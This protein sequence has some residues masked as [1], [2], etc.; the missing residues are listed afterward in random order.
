MATRQVRTRPSA[1]R[2]TVARQSPVSLALARRRGV[3]PAQVIATD[4]VVAYRG[5]EYPLSDIVDIAGYKMQDTRPGKYLHVSDLLSKC[6]R[7]RAIH[8]KY[9]TKP[10]SRRLTVS[11]RLTFAQGDAIHDLLKSIA[12]D[13]DPDEVWGKW[14]CKCGELHHDEPCTYSSI[15]RTETCEYCHTLVDVYHEVSMV[16]EELWIV[17]NPDLILYKA[18]YDAYLISELKSIAPD[19][20]KTLARPKPEHVL[21]VV[22][23]WYLMRKLG[24]R[25]LDRV[26]I[27]YASKGWSFTKPFLEFV[28]DPQHELHRLEPMIEDAIAHRASVEGAELPGRTFCSSASAKDAKSCEVCQICFGG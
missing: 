9:G 7:K 28:I 21:Q 16:D 22:F 12:R 6:I 13:G 4:G 10:K 17:G 20:F 27:F 25:V 15:N 3:A 24:Y 23:Y 26:S 2:E 5:S 14:S 1:Q 11:D 8:Q 19:Q 18:R